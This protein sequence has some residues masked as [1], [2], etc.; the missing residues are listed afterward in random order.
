MKTWKTGLLTAAVASM[1]LAATAKAPQDKD[2]VDTAIANGQFTTL[3]TWL[4][5]AQ[6]TSI[7][8][9][10]GP[11]TVFAAT[12]EAFNKLSEEERDRIM[13]NPELLTRTLNYH[14]ISGRLMAADLSGREKVESLV[15]DRDKVQ[16]LKIRT[17]ENGVVWV[18]GSKVIMSNVIASNGVI[19]VLDTTLTPPPKADTRATGTT[20][21]GN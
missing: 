17:D 4:G 8:K 1:A 19:H 13:R 21:G 2:I 6:M 18:N 15:R 16:E 12:D 14:I 9:G 3:V 10:P 11:Y 7:L 20:G 5:Q